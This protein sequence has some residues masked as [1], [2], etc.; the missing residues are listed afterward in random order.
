MMLVLKTLGKQSQEN[1][2]HLTDEP[3]IKYINNLNKSAKKRDMTEMFPEIDKNL[4]NI[5]ENFL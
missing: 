2:S 1:F 4:V 3:V 5:L